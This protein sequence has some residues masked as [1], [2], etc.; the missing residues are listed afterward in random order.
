M[1]DIQH[2]HNLNA[3]P[4]TVV[5]EV[6]VI[7]GEEILGHYGLGLYC[8]CSD[9]HNREASVVHYLSTI[10]STPTVLRSLHQN[11]LRKFFSGLMQSQ[12]EN[13]NLSLEIKENCDTKQ[14]DLTPFSKQT[15]WFHTF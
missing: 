12:N 7:R 1:A 4:D 5:D 11:M 2:R 14:N 10:H 6:H 15:F 13:Y 9:G 3:F 8:K